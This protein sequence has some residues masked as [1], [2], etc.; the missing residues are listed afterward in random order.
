MAAAV[1]AAAALAAGAAAPAHG[2]TV[3]GNGFDVANLDALLAQGSFTCGGF[4]VPNIVYQPPGPGCTAYSAGAFGSGSGSHVVPSGFGVITSV[5]IR[6]GPATGPMRLSVLMG[7]RGIGIGVSQCCVGRTQTDVFTPA[8]NQVTE[9]R[10][11][12]PVRNELTATNVYE[13]DQLALTGV[14]PQSVIPA[15]RIPEDPNLGF[16][17]TSGIYFPAIAPGVEAFGTP[18]SASIAIMFQATWEP[19]ADRDGFGDETQDTCPTDARSQSARAAACPPRGGGTTARLVPGR[20]G[21]DARGR[22]TLRVTVPRAGRLSVAG[23]GTSARFVRRAIISSTRGRT[24]RVT[25]APTSAALAVMRRRA[26]PVRVRLTFT[27]RSGA[28]LRATVAYTF[29]RR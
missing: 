8:P 5:R 2:A 16:V 20:V 7:Q 3:F 21:T 28:T 4:N 29:R 12:I 24:V 13:F 23:S 17:F 27:P 25:I 1:A 15:V 11:R 19:D 14:G 9:L 22:G 18:Y 26:L 10:T 6:Q